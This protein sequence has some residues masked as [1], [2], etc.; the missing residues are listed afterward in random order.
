MYGDSLDK[1]KLKLW[2]MR[3]LS[4]SKYIDALDKHILFLHTLNQLCT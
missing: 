1:N 3:Y 4:L 2:T